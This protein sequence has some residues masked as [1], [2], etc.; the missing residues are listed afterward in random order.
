MTDEQEEIVAALERGQATLEQQREAA[1]M[2][3]DLDSQV[4]ELSEWNQRG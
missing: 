4:R 1:R 3:R 2:L